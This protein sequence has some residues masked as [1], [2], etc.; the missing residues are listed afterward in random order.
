MDCCRIEN[1]GCNGGDPGPALDCV[2]KILN[3]IMKDSDYPY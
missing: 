2:M 1:R 3:G